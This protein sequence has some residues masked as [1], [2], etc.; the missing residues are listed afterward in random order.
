MLMVDKSLYQD[1]HK[2]SVL[3]PNVNQYDGEKAQ[4]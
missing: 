3:V 4:I 2:D 1:Y